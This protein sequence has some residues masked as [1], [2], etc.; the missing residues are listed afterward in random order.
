MNYQQ[1]QKWFKE[2]EESDYR[3]FLSSLKESLPVEINEPELDIL[4][5]WCGENNLT[6]EIRWSF[7]YSRRNLV[8]NR[9]AIFP[10][11]HSDF[12]LRVNKGEDD[13]FWT[14]KI[15]NDDALYLK[16]EYFKCD[17]LGG[18]IKLLSVIK[19]ND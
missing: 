16:C 15:T 9:I 6:V 17:D 4:E 12:E 3:N 11:E 10:K 14:K 1:Y 13:Y 5:K 8:R 18:L 19:S 2:I 7:P